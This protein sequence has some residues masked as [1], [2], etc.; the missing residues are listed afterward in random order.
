MRIIDDINELEKLTNEE[1]IEKLC[2]KKYNKANL[3]ELIR[4]LIKRI[5]E[6][7]ETIKYY[8]EKEING[9]LVEFDLANL[10][11]CVDRIKIL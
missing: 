1:L 11:C 3:R 4:R 7:K 5:K 8:Q 6:Q 10:E 2:K 9:R